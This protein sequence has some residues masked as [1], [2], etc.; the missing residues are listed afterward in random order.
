MK[1]EGGKKGAWFEV[2]TAMESTCSAGSSGHTDVVGVK[3]GQDINHPISVVLLSS[4]VQM[5]GQYLKL[6]HNRSLPHPFQF[7]VQ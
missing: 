3:L 2:F 6:Y 1:G 5:S 7:I 4:C